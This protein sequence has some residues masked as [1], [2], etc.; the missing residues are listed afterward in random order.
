VKLNQIQE[1]RYQGSRYVDWV[2]Q[3]I[4]K[5]EQQAHEVDGET[6]INW[7]NT[8]PQDLE[9]PLDEID[10]LKKEMTEHFGKPIEHDEQLYS[11]ATVEHGSVRSGVITWHID[12]PRYQWMWPVSYY[13]TR[14][15][16]NTGR[17]EV[18]DVLYPDE[19]TPYGDNR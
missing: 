12:S 19:L 15:P 17:L 14:D 16:I 13:Y 4:E 18:D 5:L 6:Y 2:R 11:D 1:A 9:I 8:A 10:T 7:Q 3:A